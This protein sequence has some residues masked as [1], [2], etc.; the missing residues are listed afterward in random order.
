METISG[1][2]SYLCK[3]GGNIISESQIQVFLDSISLKM[4]K[5]CIFMSITEL[6]SI[7]LVYFF[8]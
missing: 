3:V 6:P 8:L 4:M 2:D 7:I 5:L 1:T